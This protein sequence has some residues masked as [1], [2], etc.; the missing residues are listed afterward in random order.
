MCLV[1]TVTIG[2]FSGITRV[3]ENALVSS[4]V[5]ILSCEMDDT[6]TC[7]AYGYDVHAVQV[8]AKIM[9]DDYLFLDCRATAR[10]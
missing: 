5:L 6:P 8:I 7:P 10:L 1:W 9:H 4:N 3:S 2:K